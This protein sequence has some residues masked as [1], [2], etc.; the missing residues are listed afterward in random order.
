MYV[1]IV[2]VFIYLFVP[3]SHSPL[4]RVD[5]Q[6]SKVCSFCFFLSLTGR[7]KQA[8]TLNSSN[9]VTRWRREC[10]CWCVWIPG[11]VS[12]CD[13]ELLLDNV[14]SYLLLAFDPGHC[15]C[16]FIVYS[17]CSFIIFTFCSFALCFCGFMCACSQLTDESPPLS[18]AVNGSLPTRTSL[19]LILTNSSQELCKI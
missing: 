4:K 6:T 8:D 15:S 12:G 10:P 3:V 18:A 13:C 17:S 19:W 7:N 9:G 5:G 1:F 14:G 11:E 2:Y 16:S